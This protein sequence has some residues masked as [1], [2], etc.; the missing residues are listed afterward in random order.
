MTLAFVEQFACALAKYGITQAVTGAFDSS[1]VFRAWQS[2]WNITT[3][4]LKFISAT[5]FAAELVA[6]SVTAASLASTSKR[7]TKEALLTI[8]AEEIVWTTAEALECCSPFKSCE[9]ERAPETVQTLAAITARICLL[10]HLFAVAINDA[11][12]RCARSTGTLKIQAPATA[13]PTITATDGW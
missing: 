10:A 12:R 9:V 5:A 4:T 3:F 2:N 1:G 11:G 8:A 6:S 13:N 7:A